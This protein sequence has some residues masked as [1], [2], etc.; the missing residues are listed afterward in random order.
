MT[1]DQY[2]ETTGMT[3]ADFGEKINVSGASVSRIRKGE[4]NIR[5]DL[6]R[7]I[8]NATGGA[9]SIFDLLQMR[10]PSP[11]ERQAA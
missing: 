3:A 9:V 8:V 10:K 7:E 11:S 1:L 5:L 4:Q 6:A 2:L